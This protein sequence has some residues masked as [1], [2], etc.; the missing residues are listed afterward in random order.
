MKGSF[1]SKLSNNSP[2][3]NNSKQRTT[4]STTDYADNKSINERVVQ[5]KQL[6]D[7]MWDPPVSCQ[8]VNL[9][10]PD[11]MAYP[12]YF[13][14][15]LNIYD[16]FNRT[17]NAISLV[18]RKFAKVSD[19]D[20]LEQVDSKP[21]DD[22]LKTFLQILFSNDYIISAENSLLSDIHIFQ[23]IYT[24][25]IELQSAVSVIVSFHSHLNLVLKNHFTT[26][27]KLMDLTFVFD[28]ANTVI[29]HYI[30]PA[31]AKIRVDLRT[32]QEQCQM[33]NTFKEQR[34]GGMNWSWPPRDTAATDKLSQLGTLKVTSTNAPPIFNLSSELDEEHKADG[35]DA[36]SA[37]RTAPAALIQRYT[38]LTAQ[39]N[40]L[41][42]PN[43]SAHVQLLHR[44]VHMITELSVNTSAHQCSLSLFPGMHRGGPRRAH[45]RSELG[46]RFRRGSATEGFGSSRGP[47][48]QSPRCVHLCD[49]YSCFYL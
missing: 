23:E 9:T 43:T 8:R 5:R 16:Y 17:I 27:S 26:S 45:E 2:I 19:V 42:Q 20:S 46:W 34:L 28:A 47:H 12:L 25:K 11:E 29:T 49:D 38:E 41:F 18:L 21:S 14:L 31:S 6:C 36:D 40:S 35:G 32:L 33:H 1:G 15:E 37:T 22:T 4:L 39:I 24:N 48:C 3:K 30:I 7:R 44:M 10:G 13:P